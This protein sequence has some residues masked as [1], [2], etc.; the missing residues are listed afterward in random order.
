MSGWLVFEDELLC[1]AW[2]AVSKDFVGMNKGPTFWQ[3]LH[4]SFQERTYGHTSMQVQQCLKFD[5]QQVFQGIVSS[6]TYC[7]FSFIQHCVYVNGCPSFLHHGKHIRATQ[8][9]EKY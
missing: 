7:P 6:H 5:V 4:D 2:L 8:C 9:V 1:N 3:N